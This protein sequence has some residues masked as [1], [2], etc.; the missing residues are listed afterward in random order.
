MGDRSASPESLDVDDVTTLGLPV[1]YVLAEDDKALARPGEEF[2]ARLGVKPVL[3][4]GGHESLLTHPDE[5]TE[6]LLAV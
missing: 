5:L 2:A 3:V 4:P 6:A 1:A